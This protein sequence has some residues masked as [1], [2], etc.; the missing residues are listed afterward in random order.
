[1]KYLVNSRE[2]NRSE[3]IQMVTEY[4]EVNHI[5]SDTIPYVLP[6]HTLA[7]SIDRFA[8]KIAR[9][10]GFDISVVE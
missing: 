8:V 6:G 9:H 4:I 10:L 1:M 5:E 7:D 3:L 2:T